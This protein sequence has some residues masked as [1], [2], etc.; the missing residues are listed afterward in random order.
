MAAYVGRLPN[1]DI[2]VGRIGREP[3]VLTLQEAQHVLRDLGPTIAVVVDAAVMKLTRADF[4]A[5]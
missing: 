3:I 4:K 1:G 2:V 5:E